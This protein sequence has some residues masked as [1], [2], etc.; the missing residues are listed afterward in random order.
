MHARFHVL[1]ACFLQ[2]HYL[3]E[4]GMSTT[5]ILLECIDNESQSEF[6]SS[7]VTACRDISVHL[8]Q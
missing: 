5:P 3:P 7:P 4:V 2:N 8:L 1:A 6:L